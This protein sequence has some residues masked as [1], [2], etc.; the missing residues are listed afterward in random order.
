MNLGRALQSCEKRGSF[1]KGH[2]WTAPKPLTLI[3]AYLTLLLAAMR[4]TQ[5]CHAL[6]K[7]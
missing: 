6:L 5:L 1:L 3:Y 4:E 2:W 7:Q